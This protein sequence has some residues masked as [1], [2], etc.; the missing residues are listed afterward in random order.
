MNGQALLAVVVFGGALL[1]IFG[2]LYREA[3]RNYRRGELDM[4]GIRLLRWALLGQLVIYL[5]LAAT[6]FLT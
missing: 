2:F 5:L 4:D 3:V 6:A 1:V